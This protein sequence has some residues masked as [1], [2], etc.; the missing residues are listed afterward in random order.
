M[1]TTKQE[2]FVQEII[3][4]KSQREAYKAAYNC[5]NMKDENID[6][7]ASNLFADGKV[8]ARYNELIEESANKALWT[9]E[10]AVN[11]LVMI[12]DEALKHLK[13]Q[14]D[15]ESYIDSKMAKVATDAIKELNNM[16]GYNEHNIN[17]NNNGNLDVKITV[18][19]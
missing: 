12:K 4:G 7:K 17:D 8:R 9:R 19:K 16:Y 15:D 18:V 13:R 2:K 3:K 6:S 11:D 5:K 1:L 10:E 14:H